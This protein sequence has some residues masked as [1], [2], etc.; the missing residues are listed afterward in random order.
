MALYIYFTNND[1]RVVT[2]WNYHIETFL[3]S[4]IVAGS[5][6]AAPEA[7]PRPGEE[8]GRLLM[9]SFEIYNEVIKDLIASRGALSGL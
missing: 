7:S 3:I 5:S 2:I 9:Y 4:Q 1:T 6:Y 8:R